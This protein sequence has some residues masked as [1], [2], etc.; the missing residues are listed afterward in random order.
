MIG[1]RGGLFDD[2]LLPA[3]TVAIRA[4]VREFADAYFASPRSRVE[5]C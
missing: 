5:L 3:E 4:E 1:E 2:L